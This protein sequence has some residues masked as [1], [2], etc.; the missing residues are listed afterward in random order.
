MG[1]RVFRFTKR[2][3]SAEHEAMLAAGEDRRVVWDTEIAGFGVRLT[4]AGAAAFIDY[5]DLTRAKRRMTIGRLLPAELTV[6]QARQRAAAYKIAVRAGGDPIAEKRAAA[7][8][9]AQAEAGFTIE[10]AIES[11]LAKRAE[12]WS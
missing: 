10:Q 8:A 4:R 9:A 1:E 6:E 5:R 3:L 11:W 7:A 12:D 2:R